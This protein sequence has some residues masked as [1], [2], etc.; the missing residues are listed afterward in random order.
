MG[1]A[2]LPEGLES[3]EPT[4]LTQGAAVFAS[5]DEA[6]RLGG[7]AKEPGAGQT[8]FGVVGIFGG[9][10]LG[11]DDYWRFLQVLVAKGVKTEGSPSAC[12]GGRCLRN[13]G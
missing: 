11:L 3:G 12:K 10:A 4:P 9:Q 5:V 13:T 6:P 2:L 8:V 7:G 1:V